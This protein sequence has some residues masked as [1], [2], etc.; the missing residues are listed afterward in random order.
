[1]KKIDDSENV[2]MLMKQLE[3]ENGYIFDGPATND[4]LNSEFEEWH[5][6]VNLKELR[7][8]HSVERPNNTKM[9]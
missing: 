7:D 6:N 4:A 3:V 2:V 1:M 8:T 5:H 9:N